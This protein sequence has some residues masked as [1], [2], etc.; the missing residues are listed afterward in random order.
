MFIYCSGDSWEFSF[1][2]WAELTCENFPLPPGLSPLLKSTRS[3]RDSK[4][5]YFSE[6]ESTRSRR[7]QNGQK[8][9]FC[10]NLQGP[11]ATQFTK[12][13][14]AQVISENFHF[15]PV[16]RSCI[17]TVKILKSQHATQ[18][19][20]IITAQVIS[21]NFYFP[22]GLRLCVSVVKIL[23]SQGYKFIWYI[24]WR[25]DCWEFLPAKSRLIYTNACCATFTACCSTCCTTPTTLTCLTTAL[26]ALFPLH[27][28]HFTPVFARFGT[29]YY[30]CCVR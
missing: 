30:V 14:T 10:S 29:F 3:S 7:Y 4:K 22:P 15:P 20:S 24:E 18:F 6:I 13:N 27:S 12:T 17:T 11:L 21:A 16:L 5:T 28:S 19:T 23:K 2:T 9:E 25:A 1:S 26:L 8:Q